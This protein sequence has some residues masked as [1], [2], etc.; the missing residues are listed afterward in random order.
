MEKIFRKTDFICR[1]AM[2]LLLLVTSTTAWAK[3]PFGYVNVC[4]GHQGSIYLELW[5]LDEDDLNA[6]TTIHVC[7]RQNGQEKSSYNIM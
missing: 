6:R 1:A 5:A 2:L 3:D 4:T 7:L